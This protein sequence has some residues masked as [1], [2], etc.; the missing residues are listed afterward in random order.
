MVLLS[1]LQSLFLWILLHTLP[2]VT[3][4]PISNLA[5]TFLASSVAY[6]FVILASVSNPVVVH[7]AYSTDL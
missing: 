4:L 7:L 3:L 6:T 1:A 5:G 2:S